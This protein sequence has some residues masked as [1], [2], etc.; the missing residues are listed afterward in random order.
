VLLHITVLLLCQLAGEIIARLSGLPVPGPI[1]G[2]VLLF[3]GLLIKGGLPEG[4]EKVGNAFLSHLSLLFVP[5]GV[6]VMVHFQ[7][8]AREWLAISIALVFSTAATVAV[9]GWVMQR[10]VRRKADTP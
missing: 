7:L 6:G 10:L 9:T 1:I 3:F 2:M 4:L 8:L 5:A